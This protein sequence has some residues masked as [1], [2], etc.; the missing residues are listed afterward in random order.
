MHFPY[1][2]GSQQA[3][4]PD[5]VSAKCQLPQRSVTEATQK[6]WQP[7]PKAIVQIQL[8]NREMV[9][10]DGCVLISSSS[11][12]GEKEQKGYSAPHVK[13]RSSVAGSGFK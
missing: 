11:S 10:N 7:F 5:E 1:Q 4:Q 8:W 9:D 6:Q 3:G 12:H 13:P 2:S